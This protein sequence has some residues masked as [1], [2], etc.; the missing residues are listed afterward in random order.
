MNIQLALDRFS[1]EEAIQIAKTS[2]EFVDW[3]EVGTSIIKEYGVESVQKIKNAFPHKVIVADSKTIDNAYYEFDMCFR[4]G[5]D[6]ATVM[7]VSPVATIQACIESANKFGKKVMIDLLNTSEDQKK[8][9]FQFKEAIFCSHVSKD[10]QEMYGKK[11]IITIQNDDPSL[12]FAVAGGITLDT[13]E[14]FK[15]MKPSVVIIGSAITKASDQRIA[16]E[17]FKN[18]MM[19]WNEESKNENN[20]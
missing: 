3:I 11:N 9:L 17:Q 4:T 20:R 5:A 14:N 13:I 2:E 15:Q 7:G 16:A 8:T 19:Q 18:I 6:I 10:E 1:V 12:Q